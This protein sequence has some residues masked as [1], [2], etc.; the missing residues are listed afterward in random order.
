MRA[1]YS[2]DVK[3]Q[4][5]PLFQLEEKYNPIFAAIIITFTIDK[6]RESIIDCMNIT[7]KQNK[8]PAKLLAALASL[9]IGLP[10]T[11][12]AAPESKTTIHPETQVTDH[13]ESQASDPSADPDVTGTVEVGG[14]FTYLPQSKLKDITDAE[15]D[16]IFSGYKGCFVQKEPVRYTN[17]SYNFELAKEPI[18][19]CSTFKIVNSLIGLETGV[20]KDENHPMKWDG[21]EH[22]IKPWNQD[23]TLKSAVQNSVVWYFQN[24]AKEIGAQRMQH[25]LNLFDYGNKDISGGITRFWLESSLKISAFQQLNFLD[26]LQSS[27]LP[28]SQRTINITKEVLFLKETP[29]GRLYGKTGS[30]TGDTKS[31]KSPEDCNLGWFVGWVVTKDGTYPF[32][33][34]IRGKGAWGKKA[35]EITET[36]LEKQG[37]L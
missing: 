8:L 34:N 22:T 10:A 13:P 29:K 1:L 25:Y 5:W 12:Q 19:P 26:R 11:G 36:I 33:T 27:Q 30:G 4:R 24:V 31:F 18:S 23:Q 17:N 20:L 15:L 7:L 21:V 32:A 3:R 14:P 6:R 28:L 35:R 16:Q 37:L 2:I 9:T